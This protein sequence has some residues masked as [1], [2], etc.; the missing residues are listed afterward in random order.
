MK[1]K[2]SKVREPLTKAE[3]KVMEK[4]S[5]TELFKICQNQDKTILKL[6]K[7]HHRALRCLASY[8]E[9]VKT[10]FR[11]PPHF[12]EDILDEMIE[13]GVPP[14]KREPKKEV[15]KSYS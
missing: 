7:E 14:D 11:S 5:K 9:I 12:F 2:P 8:R 15:D 3:K 6:E 4:F 1:N 13:E 10:E